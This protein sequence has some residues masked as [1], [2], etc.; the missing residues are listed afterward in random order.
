MLAHTDSKHSHQR[1]CYALM[2]VVFIW[3]FVNCFGD[4]FYVLIIFESVS[5]SHLLALI[6]Y[7]VVYTMSAK[8]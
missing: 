2:R 1:A 5:L 7:A 6:A 8:Q 4:I 3:K